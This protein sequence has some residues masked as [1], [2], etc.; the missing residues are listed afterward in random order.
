MLSI[1]TSDYKEI[2]LPA[3]QSVNF[4]LLYITQYIF[5]RSK[6]PSKVSFIP[7]SFCTSHPLPPVPNTADS[8]K[9]L[10]RGT[11]ILSYS[12]ST[13]RTVDVHHQTSC[14]HIQRQRLWPIKGSSKA[15]LEQN[16]DMYSITLSHLLKFWLWLFCSY[17]LSF[18]SQPI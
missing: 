10:R 12:C 14:T 1:A 5:M 9:T 11:F 16:W 17:C 18:Y 7:P 3:A 15:L 2:L 6:N 4:S 13:V 8:Y